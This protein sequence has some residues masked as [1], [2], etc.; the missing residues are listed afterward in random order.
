MQKGEFAGGKFAG[1]L[2]CAFLCWI[3][4]NDLLPILAINRFFGC[5]HGAD[6]NLVGDRIRSG[7]LL[8]VAY[9]ALAVGLVGDA[10]AQSG[11]SIE[12]GDFDIFAVNGEFAI[13]EDALNDGCGSGFV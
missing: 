6:F 3:S 1:A 10:S 2:C 11:F 7:N 5:A 4:L 9:D 13:G 8:G 12:R